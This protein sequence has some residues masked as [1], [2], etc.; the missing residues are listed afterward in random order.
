MS[1]Q[2]EEYKMGSKREHSD[3]PR[4]PNRSERKKRKG[5]GWGQKTVY[6]GE[7]NR[8]T[9]KFE[10]LY[11]S[12]ATMKKLG[13]VSKPAVGKQTGNGMKK[14]LRCQK[15]QRNVCLHCCKS[16]LNAIKE[17]NQKFADYLS[18]NN[19]WYQEVNVFVESN[20]TITPHPFT[21]SCCN[22]EWQD[23][24]EQS[25]ERVHVNKPATTYGGYLHVV[26]PNLLLST[27]FDK[28]C[29]SHCF[30]NDKVNKIVGLKH[31]VVSHAICL[32]TKPDSSESHVLYK[33]EH[34]L[35]LR[36]DSS[37]RVAIEIYKSDY[38]G[39]RSIAIKLGDE[40]QPSDIKNSHIILEDIP[41]GCRLKI[42]LAT[43]NQQDILH[44]VS[45]CFPLKPPTKKKDYWRSDYLSYNLFSDLMEACGTRRMEVIQNNTGGVVQ[46]NYL[47]KHFLKHH[48]VFSRTNKA[49]VMLL[50]ES[51][52]KLC[53]L[54]V[55]SEGD[56]V[57]TMIIVLLNMVANQR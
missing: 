27:S 3:L 9:F 35:Q 22:F 43:S 18:Q 39:Q 24:E 28:T 49:V 44:L 29:I 30:A 25:K 26:E 51:K 12:Q 14:F 36:E 41:K 7:G 4:K 38:D 54:Y 57:A 52:L 19:Q 42:I 53:C 5:S 47:L 50:T 34:N 56:A 48:S 46:G 13:V 16:I 23:L 17:K 33:G 15:C 8:Q 6:R 11:H 32:K 10:C 2:K 40:V 37:V 45:V 55:N 31:G 1:K 21:G 20:G